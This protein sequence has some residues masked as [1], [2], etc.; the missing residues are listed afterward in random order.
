M[1]LIWNTVGF[2]NLQ[3]VYALSPMILE[4]HQGPSA[5][6]PDRSGYV[7]GWVLCGFWRKQAAVSCPLGVKACN[8]EC[9]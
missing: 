6:K 4:G 9:M 2:M 8:C 7:H 5:L 3:K 1:A